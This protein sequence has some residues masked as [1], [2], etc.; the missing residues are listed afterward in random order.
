[1]FASINRHRRRLSNRNF[2]PVIQC[3]VGRDQERSQMKSPSLAG[4]VGAAVLA[5]PSFMS[6][7]TNPFKSV[8]EEVRSVGQELN[9]RPIYFLVTLVIVVGISTVMTLIFS[10]SGVTQGYVLRELQAER[11]TL[12]LEN[13]KVTMAIS[14]AQA[15]NSVL[16]NDVI[17]Y[18]RPAK[19]V[20]Y[21]DAPKDA[22]KEV[23]MR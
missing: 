12:V 5:F 2:T 1:M 11:Q 8:H 6:L 19:N 23:A 3:S 21:L 15:L 4:G 18:M 20:V 13:E 16:T 10:T 7:F 22:P 17:Q 14:S 9:I